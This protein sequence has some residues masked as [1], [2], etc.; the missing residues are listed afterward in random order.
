MRPKG[1][2][3]A[4]RSLRFVEMRRLLHET[5]TKKATLFSIAADARRAKRW[6]RVARGDAIP[7]SSPCQQREMRVAHGWGAPCPALIKAMGRHVLRLNDEDHPLL[8]IR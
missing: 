1:H 4:R 8:G 3:R 2:R 6:G 5:H 7:A